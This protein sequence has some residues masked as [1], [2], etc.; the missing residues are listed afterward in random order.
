MRIAV[1]LVV[2][3]AIAGA[4]VFALVPRGERPP[5]GSER[6]EP[7]HQPTA[8]ATPVQAPIEPVDVVLGLRETLASAL[9]RGGVSGQDAAEIA[10]A[11]RRVVDVRRLRPGERI[12]LARRGDGR[13]AAVTYWRSPAERFAVRQTA[14]GRGWTAEPM[15]VSVDTRIEFVGG[16]VEDSLFASVE[17][18]GERPSL[19][20]SFVGLLEWDFDFA[21]DA[22]PGDRFDMLVEKRYVDGAFAGYGDILVARYETAER[23]PLTAVRFAGADGRAEFFDASG[24]SV[25]KMFLRAPLDFTRVT[26]GFS[27]AR[28]HPVLGGLR[29]HLAID[30]GAPMGTPVRSVAD[31]VVEAAGWRGGY[32][33]SVTVRHGR[34]YRTMYNHLS[35]ALVSRGQRVRQR[36]VIARV[37]STGLSTGPHLDYRVISHGRF[38]NP[39]GEK[40]VPGTPVPRER[41]RAFQGH[42]EALL[43]QLERGA[44]LPFGPG[45][46]SCSRPPATGCRAGDSS[47][48]TPRVFRS[49]I[50]GLDS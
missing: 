3:S 25:R 41:L 18:L 29:P 34:G 2:A 35:R 30:Y 24:R 6:A 44:A 14:D 23:A 28:R 36:D 39:L 19:A 12:V 10:A 4:A 7:A 26:S 42:V 37:G 15:R 11:L 1:S 49:A 43:R 17:R 40:F 46:L 21:A 45:V 20:R 9:G 8:E 13:P 50:R 31:G 27:H 16:R 5:P 22:L 47:S 33:I 38:V 48:E 32:G